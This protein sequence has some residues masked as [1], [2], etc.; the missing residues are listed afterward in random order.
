MEKQ[1][2]IVQSMMESASVPLNEPPQSKSWWQAANVPPAVGVYSVRFSPTITLMSA[3]FLVVALASILWLS[4]SASKLDQ[5]E[6]PEQALNLM[7][8]RT[9]DMQEGLKRAPRWEQLLFS[10]TSDDSDT[11]LAHEIEWYRELSEISEDPLVPLQL[12]ILQAEAGHVSQ[13]ILSAHEWAKAEDPL[14]QFAN[15]VMAAYGEGPVQDAEQYALLQAEVAET[16]PAGWFYDRLA[17][18]LAHRAN[19]TELVARI[20][21][22]AAERVDRQFLWSHRLTLVDLVAMATGTVVCLLLWIRRNEPSS[23]IRL[24]EPGVPPPW[25]GRIGAAVLLRGGAIGVVLTGLF[26]I[27][28]PPDNVPFRALAIP[29]TNAPLLFLAY[30]YLLRPS[31]M[32]FDDGFGLEIGWANAGRLVAAVSAVVAAGLWGGWVMERLLE[33]FHLTSHWAEWFDADLVWA[34]PSMTAISLIEY[35]VFAPLFEE[36]VFRGLLFA[37]LRRKFSFLPAALI[38]AVIFGVAHGYGLVGLLSV[39]WSGLLW[40][41]IYEKTGSLLPGILAHAINNLLVCLAVMALLR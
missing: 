12:A 16:L 20:Q 1:R 35:V 27:V 29:L 6:S 9:M 11:E 25:P 26:T 40:A 5:V 15:L 23:F 36:L 28:A 32:T 4:A 17:E 39:C 34:S 33:P 7:V 41:W 21:E 13:A 2:V 24:H 22:Q 14:P 18:R 19:D 37:I 38:S 8:S 3:L 31:G 10:W 30:R